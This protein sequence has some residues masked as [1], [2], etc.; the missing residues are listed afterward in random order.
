M[1][2]VPRRW[3]R[4]RGAFSR[5][6]SQD[7]DLLMLPQYSAPVE[8]QHRQREDVRQLIAAA[9]WESFDAGTR[10]FL[11]NYINAMADR[12]V[13]ELGGRRDDAL[14]LAD[15]YIALAAEKVAWFGAPYNADLAQV[16]L[17]TDTLTVT[18]ENLTGRSADELVRSGVRR[19]MK[20]P[21]ASTLGPIDIFNDIV[22]REDAGAEEPA[23]S[24]AP[25]EAVQKPSDPQPEDFSV[26]Q[27]SEPKVP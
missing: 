5:L 22:S 1:R 16:A 21:I 8:E 15:A 10:E 13:A 25:A 24:E 11:N 14:A 3:R 9:G 26:E 6:E 23:E 17:A 18:F 7:L 19:I 20:D 2:W 4:R 12:S 27:H